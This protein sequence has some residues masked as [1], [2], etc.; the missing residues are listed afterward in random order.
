VAHRCRRQVAFAA[1]DGGAPPVSEQFPGR[2]VTRDSTARTSWPRPA[3]RHRD[4]AV[5]T[6]V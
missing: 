3:A 4:Q 6:A 5:D 2:V 1:I